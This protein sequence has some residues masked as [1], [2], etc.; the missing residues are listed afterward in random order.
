MDGRHWIFRSG[1]SRNEQLYNPIMTSFVKFTNIMDSEHS[2][3]SLF[4]AVGT[5]TVG[6]IV[7]Y[8]RVRE[9]RHPVAIE[10]TS[11]E[12]YLQYET[13]GMVRDVAAWLIP[14]RVVAIRVTGYKDRVASIPRAI[15]SLM[16]LRELQLNGNSITEIPAA[17]RRLTNLQLLDV[18]NN[19][20]SSLPE[21]IG[22]LAALTSLNAM[23]NSLKE[24]PHSIGKLT[25]LRRLGL[26]DNRLETLPSSLGKLLELHEL[27]LTN[28]CLESLP[29]EIE[30]CRS[31]V[32]L[33]ASHNKIQKLPESISQLPNLELLRVANCNITDM[34]KSLHAARSLSW[35]SMASN[36]VCHVPSPRRGTVQT[37]RIDDLKIGRKLG[38]GASGD[39]YEGMWQ[40]QKVA[41]KLFR[42]DC[43]P[44]G[45]AR[46]EIAI[47]SYLSDRNLVKVLAKLDNPSI[48]LVLEFVDAI[49]LAEKPNS[50]SLLRCRW[51]D[52]I[53]FS[54]NF[55]C[56]VAAGVASA[57]EHM[58]ARG[59]L[60]GDVY[61]H[62]VLVDTDGNATLCDYGASS[63]YSK[64]SALSSVY[65][66]M[67]T[68]AFGLLLRDLIQRVD[69]AFEGMEA[70]LDAQKQILLIIQQCTTGTPESRPRISVIARKLKSLQKSVNSRWSAS[71]RS[72]SRILGLANSHRGHDGPQGSMTA[73]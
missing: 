32:K 72:D 2:K 6:A 17:I 23:G 43:S 12:E 25:A 27:F 18:S 10:I 56:N 46:E 36:P 68:R 47:A 61:A 7:L 29:E 24:L 65:E 3:R 28:N 35:L 13:G 70:S 8:N 66:G 50:Q 21:E 48:G 4:M 62:N 33:Q 49:P 11:L 63:A 53:L 55:V 22:D 19:F 59:V 15:S 57:L 38:D 1:K 40:N 71:P 30:G 31:L 51:N 67:E 60:H 5:A 73:R 58:H 37:V 14:P 39:V 34:P 45:N 52:G 41:V 42:E 44:D 9:R 20:L 54:L 69:I 26:K 16:Q 64:N